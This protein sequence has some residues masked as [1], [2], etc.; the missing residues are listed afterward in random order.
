MRIILAFLTLA[1]LAGPAR[2]ALPFTDGFDTDVP[3]QTFVSVGGN[4]LADTSAVQVVLTPATNTPNSLCVVGGTVSNCT[5]QGG[6]ATKVWTVL[7]LIPVPGLPPVASTTNGASLQFFFGTNGF[8]NLVTSQGELVLGNDIQGALLSTVD[9]NHF[10]HIFVYQDFVHGV[11]AVLLNG[12]VITQDVSCLTAGSTFNRMAVQSLDLASYLDNVNISTQTPS[13]LDGNGDG[14][15]DAQELQTYGYVARTNLTVGA[16][17]M[18]SSLQAAINVARPRDTIVVRTYTLNESLSIDHAVTLSGVN[19]TN[20]GSCA[21]TAGGVLTL[22]TGFDN[23]GTLTLAGDLELKAAFQVTDIVFTGSGFLNTVNTGLAVS[24]RG[25]AMSGRFSITAAAWNNGLA[26]ASLPMAEDFEQYAVGTPISSLW[27][28]GWGASSSDGQVVSTPVHGGVRA[29]QVSG[30]VSNRVDGTGVSKV[31]TDLYLSPR[32]GTPPESLDTNT[33]SVLLYVGTN[34]WLTL[35]NAGQWDVL[36]NGV[37]G[38]PVSPLTEG[39][40]SHVSLFVDLNLAQA[41]I[42]QDGQLLRQEVPFP[43][44]TSVSPYRAMQVANLD[45]DAYLDNVAIGAQIPSGLTGDAD[46]NGV[47]DATEV[48]NLGGIGFRGAIYL[49]R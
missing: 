7:D 9:T 10:A 49:I 43:R 11:G 32:I 33:A 40:Y 12:Q 23:I 15:S 45:G 17:Q 19:F 47:L 46:G 1:V 18:F 13:S 41:A 6:S 5:A 8:M 29:A 36:S 34:G 39:H 21:I 22:L 14:V 16:G 37:M 26:K 2:A 20:T 38:G 30:V 44:G 24:S 27:F 25:V 31:W 4:W 35:Y 42:F 28:R 3:G 48:T